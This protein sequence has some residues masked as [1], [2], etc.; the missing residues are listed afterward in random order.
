MKELSLNILDIVENSTKAGA[1]L[2][3]IEIREKSADNSLEILI[4]DDGRGMSKELLDRVTDP[5]TTTRT[6]RKVGLGLPLFKMAAEQTGGRLEIESE[7]GVG[8]VVK[9]IFFTNHIDYTPVG[10]MGETFSVL[11][12]GHPNTD[13]VYSRSKDGEGFSLSTIEMREM[14]GGISLATPDVLAWATEYIKEQTKE[15][16]IGGVI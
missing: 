16:S 14:L 13:F 11:L 15:L 7:L 8:T 12:M 10:E 2:V 3:K 5:F 4:S 9:A 1:S 6:T